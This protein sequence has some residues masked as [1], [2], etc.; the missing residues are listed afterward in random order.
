MSALGSF[1]DIDAVLISVCFSPVRLKFQAP[2]YFSLV[3]HQNSSLS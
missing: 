1:G 3:A 2:G